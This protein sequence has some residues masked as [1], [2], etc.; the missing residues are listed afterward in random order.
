MSDVHRLL[1]E[2]RDVA[3][4]HDADFLIAII[5]RYVQVY[6]GAWEKASLVYRLSAEKYS[7][8]E[9][10]RRFAELLSESGF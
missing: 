5:P 1:E 8:F 7:I 4:E 10:N 9:P 6:D 3:R 2:T